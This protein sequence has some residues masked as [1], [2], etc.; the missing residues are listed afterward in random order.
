M[1]VCLWTHQNKTMNARIILPTFGSLGDIHPFLALALELQ[2]RGHTPV[3]ATSSLYRAKIEAE[4]IEFHP[5]APQLPGPEDWDKIMPRLMDAKWGTRRLFREML[6]PA[7]RPAYHDL[8]P[9][10]KNA[11]FMVAH[12]IA[13]AAPLC[14]EKL[15]KKWLSVVL[16]PLSFWSTHDF[17][18][19]P[20]VP[21]FEKMQGDVKFHETLKSIIAWISRGWVREVARVRRE[22]NLPSGAHPLFAGAFSPHG[23]LAMFSRELAAPQPD[24]PPHTFQTGYCFYDRKGELF[25]DA[26]YSG[27]LAPA[28]EQF[29]QEGEAPLVFTLGSAAVFAA[30]DF[31]RIAVESARALN[32]RAILLIGEESN[33]PP[34]LP[35]GDNQ[36]AAFEY[37]PFS[38]LFSRAALVVHQG[39][40]GTTGQVLRAGVPNLVM[41]YSHD[42][43]D[44][45]RHLVRRG[46]AGV[47]PRSRCRATEMTAAL[48]TL[49]KDAEYSRRAREIGAHVQAENGAAA[50]ADAIETVL[51]S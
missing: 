48:R 44:N 6:M 31:Y 28:I 37:A 27:A 16:A 45:A 42:Q 25:G 15:N 13:F 26:A 2:A 50:A 18:V 19:A 10:L 38:E 34:N 36:I 8:L 17:P 29:L 41:P 43:P 3:I 7:V 12:S 11:D 32:R 23:V 30:R 39:G 14:A 47:L 46:V 40:A 51:K 49:L 20:G 9:V 24:W 35:P 5:M 22:E 1:V 4:N 33:R 21:A